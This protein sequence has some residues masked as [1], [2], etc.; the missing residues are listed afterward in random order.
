[1]QRY[2]ISIETLL[3]FVKLNNKHLC[4]ISFMSFRICNPSFNIFGL[5]V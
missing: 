2:I 1:M 4:Y 3:F 5:Q